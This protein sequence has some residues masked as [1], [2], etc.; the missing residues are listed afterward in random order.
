MSTATKEKAPQAPVKNKRKRTKAPSDALRDLF[1]N[2]LKDIYWAEKTLTH[3]ITKLIKQASSKELLQALDNHLNE[4][5]EQVSRLEQVFE[6]IGVKTLGSKCQAIDGLIKETE[7]SLKESESGMIK[8]AEIIACVQKSEHFQLGSYS[9]LIA[10]ARMLG[11]DEAVVLLDATRS[12]ENGT[13][14]KM[15]DLTVQTIHL[16]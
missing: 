5:E 2:E 12:E 11:E 3:F 6:L 8:D 13:M 15:A 10:F 14:Q 9:T 1:E 16:P 4:T 7:L